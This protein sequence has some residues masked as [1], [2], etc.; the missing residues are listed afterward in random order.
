MSLKTEE[1]TKTRP[2]ADRDQE[3]AAVAIG[4]LRRIERACAEAASGLAGIFE[5][6]ITD[7]AP[8]VRGAWQRKIARLPGLSLERGLTAGEVS[9]EVTYDEANTYTALGG[10][11]K[12][13]LLE[14]V[15]DASP[16][17]WR[18]AV[19]HRRDKILAASRVIATGEWTT[20]GDIAIAVGGNVRL[21]RS[22]ASVAAK[23]PTFANPHRVL[24]K[25][26]VIAPDWRD[27]D[28]KGPEECERRLRA[29]GV[30]LDEDGIADP[31]ARIGYEELQAR[32]A[33]HAVDDAGMPAA[34]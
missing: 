12:A 4:L 19:K 18:L 16:K 25:G 14:Q 7:A 5:E 13:G 15:P 22:V 24:L 9:R 8:A 1:T 17:R 20:Y 6:D 27:D 34:A 3:I 21:A 33:E 28:G 2:V 30:D 31:K 10:L 26:G 11:E 29:D 23:N 32:L